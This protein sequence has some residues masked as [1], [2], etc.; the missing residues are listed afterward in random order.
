MDVVFIANF[1]KTKIQKSIG[2]Q[3]GIYSFFFVLFN[4]F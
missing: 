3:M 4:F 1:S 2:Y